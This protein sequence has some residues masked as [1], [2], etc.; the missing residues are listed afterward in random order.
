MFSQENASVD[1]IRML[2]TAQQL[3]DNTA[4]NSNLNFKP[5]QRQG[6]GRGKGSLYTVFVNKNERT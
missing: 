1:Y 6:R 2:I 5:N 4:K 3:E